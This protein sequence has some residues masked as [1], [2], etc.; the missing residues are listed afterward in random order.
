MTRSITGQVTPLLGEGEQIRHT[1][2]MVQQPG[3][4]WQLLLVGGLL[5]FL[6]TKAY[7]VAVTT[8][9]LII[10]RTRQ[11]LF[12]PAMENHGIEEIPISHISEVS[13]GGFARNRSMIFAI[14]D[15]SFRTLRLA[16]WS[17]YVSGNEAMLKEFPDELNHKRSTFAPP[18]E[19]ASSAD[20][21]ECPYCG[22]T[23]A[24]PACEQCARDVTAPRRLCEACQKW[25]PMEE[26]EC[27]H[28]HNR[29][30]QEWVRKIPLVILFLIAIVALP[31]FLGL[32]VF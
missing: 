22:T 31:I 2:F 10:I 25:T 3:L 26:A 29:P 21:R 20:R 5:L 19:G 1:A 12:S 17:V 32:Y 24:I 30:V 15:G 6:M 9:K 23:T 27:I 4:F 28:C 7:F 8:R 11:G 14:T 13:I 18:D 16:P